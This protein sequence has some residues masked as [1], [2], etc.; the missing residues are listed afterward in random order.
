[1]RDT[2]ERHYRESLSSEALACE[3]L[4]LD[5]QMLGRMLEIGVAGESE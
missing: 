5:T 2:I 3:A 1:M 4:S